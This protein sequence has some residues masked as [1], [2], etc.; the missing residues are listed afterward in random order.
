MARD[1]VLGPLI[2]IDCDPA[3]P[4]G[5][6]QPEMSDRRLHQMHCNLTTPNGL[7]P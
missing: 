5:E 6:G 4:I 1:G 7:P 2:F 3:A